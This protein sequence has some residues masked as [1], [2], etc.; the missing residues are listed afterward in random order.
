MGFIAEIH[1]AHDELPLASTIERQSSVTLRHEYETTTDDRRIQF[2]SAFDD[3]YGA[4][5]E[6]LAADPTVSDLD[7]VATFENRAIYRVV[8]DTDLQ[9][10]PDRCAEYGLFVFTV[11]SAD[12]G[13]VV[14]AHLP[15]RDAL[16]AFREW[17]RDR[18]VS[19]RVNQLYDSSVSDDR[20]YF[21]TERQHEILT[22]AYYAGYFEVP[23]GVTQDTL[24][25]RL[26]ISDSAVSQRLRRAI[27]ELI[28]ATLENKCT[29]AEFG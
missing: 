11:T 23:R 22:I 5:E 18:N 7:R 12:G 13:W 24:A 26:D 20:T 17:C 29:P 15:D 21:L 28:T 3:E 14:R 27:S 2:V 19:F 10:V 1:L 4:I 9:I 25:D 8:V 16:T 6:T